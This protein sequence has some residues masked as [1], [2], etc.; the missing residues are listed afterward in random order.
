MLPPLSKYYYGPQ[1]WASAVGSPSHNGT[2]GARKRRKIALKRSR[3]LL[4]PNSLPRFLV[5]AERCART[6][7]CS[8]SSTITRPAA[9]LSGLVGSK[10]SL[11]IGTGAGLAGACELGGRNS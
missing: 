4:T 2:N 3:H 10:L 6:I 1:G 11:A 7:S 9:I 8:T 5:D